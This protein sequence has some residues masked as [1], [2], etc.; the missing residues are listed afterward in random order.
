MASVLFLPGQVAEVLTPPTSG[1]QIRT[2]FTNML[3]RTFFSFV[4]HLD[5]VL[6]LKYARENH[7][8]Y[9]EVVG[10]IRSVVLR[11]APAK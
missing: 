1:E 10:N 9:G 3:L 8:S 4:I 7:T 5:I 11:E 6:A 2:R